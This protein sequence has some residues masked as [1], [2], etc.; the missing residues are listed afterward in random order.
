MNKFQKVALQMAKDDKRSGADFCKDESLK[1]AA[2]DWYSK[3]KG[4]KSSWSYKKALDFKNWNKT[5]WSHLNNI[6]N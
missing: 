5:Q 3:F 6:I 1:S 4:N 2:R